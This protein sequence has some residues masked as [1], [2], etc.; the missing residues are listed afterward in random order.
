[1]TRRS[2]FPQNKVLSSFGLEHFIFVKM[3]PPSHLTITYDI[4]WP[5]EC[6]VNIYILDF[7]GSD[8]RNFIF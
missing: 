2:S 6:D 5:T 1:M 4:I 7:Y 3:I 8:A